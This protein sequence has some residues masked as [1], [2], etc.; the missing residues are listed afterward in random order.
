MGSGRSTAARRGC[1]R[2]GAVDRASCQRLGATPLAGPAVPSPGRL[3]RRRRAHLPRPPRPAGVRPGPTHRSDHRHPDHSSQGRSV[4]SAGGNGD[5]GQP[6]V[7]G[8]VRASRPGSA[9][10]SHQSRSARSACSSLLQPSS[11]RPARGAM[12]PGSNRVTRAS[13]GHRPASGPG[14]GEH[15]VLGPAAHGRARGHVVGTAYPLVVA[16]PGRMNPAGRPAATDRRVGCGFGTCRPAAQTDS[17]SRP[18]PPRSP[19]W[20]RCARAGHL[21]A[22]EQRPH[23]G[24]SPCPRARRRHALARLDRTAAVRPHGRRVPGPGRLRRLCQVGRDRDVRG[25]SRPGRAR[26]S[27]ARGG[28]QRGRPCFSASTDLAIRRCRVSSVL[29]PVTWR[30][31]HDLLL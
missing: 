17:S 24:A 9:A 5:Q 8:V 14:E 27:R 29:A 25:A 1:A 15:G 30:T 18:S 20:S 11:S 21:P 22:C 23:P 4:G 10:R 19:D 2:G 7:L 28:G 16:E 12:R 26:G 3:P 31:C 13:S 6:A